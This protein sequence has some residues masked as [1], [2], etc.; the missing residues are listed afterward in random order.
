MVY[1][2]ADHFFDNIIQG[3]D[4]TLT[5]KQVIQKVKKDIK[6]Y[7]KQCNKYNKQSNYNKRFCKAMIDKINYLV[8]RY[9][10]LKD[11]LNTILTKAGIHAKTISKSSSS[12]R[13]SSPLAT[14]NFTIKERKGNSRRSNSRRSN[15]RR[16]REGHIRKTRKSSLRDQSYN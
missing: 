8:T 12:S 15:S 13:R 3:Y 7:R 10:N 6:L 1:T 14:S 11:E 16:S 4:T 9:P 2:Y 5:K